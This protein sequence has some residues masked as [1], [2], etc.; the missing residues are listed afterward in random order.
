[1]VWVLE[2]PSSC[3]SKWTLIRS[4]GGFEREALIYRV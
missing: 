4:K 1:M 2:M 3:L